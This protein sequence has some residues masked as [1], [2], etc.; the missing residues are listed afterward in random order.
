MDRRTAVD[1]RR[2]QRPV[3]QSTQ[4]VGA[5]AGVGQGGGDLRLPVDGGDLHARDVRRLPQAR[6]AVD[7]EARV[8]PAFGRLGEEQRLSAASRS[9][10]SGRIPLGRQGTA[11]EVAEAVTFLLSDSCFPTAP[12]T[13]PGRAWWWTAG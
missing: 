7:D 2:A 5:A 11:W 6:G 8:Q 13:S 4:E 9:T 1:L 12:P 10:S 3:E